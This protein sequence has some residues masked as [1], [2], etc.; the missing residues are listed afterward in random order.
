MDQ[1]LLAKAV[2][3]FIKNLTPFGSRPPRH[4]FLNR[5]HTNVGQQEFTQSIEYI[6][7]L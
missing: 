4:F 7:S 3:K 6:A 1:N 5:T 2:V